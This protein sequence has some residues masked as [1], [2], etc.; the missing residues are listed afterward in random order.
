M[1]TSDTVDIALT[2][3]R[4]ESLELNLESTAR[5]REAA[6]GHAT[7]IRFLNDSHRSCLSNLGNHREGHVQTG[8]A[9]ADADE[10]EQNREPG[11]EVDRPLCGHGTI[12]KGG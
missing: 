10:G 8:D 6:H 5:T 2:E 9:Q 3:R 4:L 12:L 7:R 1:A 11:R